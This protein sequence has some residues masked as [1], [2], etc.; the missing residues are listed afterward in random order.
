MHS[1]RSTHAAAAAQIRAELK[2][3]S[4]PA[5]VR[6]RTASMMDAVDVS[7]SDLP[8]W[9]AA[10]VRAFVGQFQYG[11]FDGTTDSY[12]VHNRRTDLP[13]VKYANV[14]CRYS[15]Q[16]QQQAWDYLRSNF[17]GLDDAPADVQQAGS[18][19]VAN[20]SEWAST[21]LHRVLSGS[22]GSFWQKPRVRLAGGA[23]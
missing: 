1:A 12:D 11:R 21:L 23:A 19:Y 15:T 4:I 5:K 3:H 13:Q 8:P 14:S 20:W 10:K 9:V 22:L 6:A 18:F 16:V 2:R 7:V 17:A